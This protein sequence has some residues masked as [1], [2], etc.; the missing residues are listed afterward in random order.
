MAGGMTAQPAEPVMDWQEK[1][2]RQMKAIEQS[3]NE[4]DRS[5]QRLTRVIIG[6]FV[7]VSLVLGVVLPAIV[8]FL[9]R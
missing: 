3:F 4:L 6:C 8:I 5:L 7:V 2:N 9:M 1:H